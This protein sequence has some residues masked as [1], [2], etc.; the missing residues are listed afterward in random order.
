MA[1]IARVVAAEVPHHV[2]QRGNRRQPVFFSTADYKAYLRLMAA[3]CG[4]QGVEVWAY[5]LMTNHVHLIVVPGSEQ[6]LARAIGEAHRRYTV[7]VNQREHWRGYLWQG[8]FSSYP[9]DDQYLLAAVRYVELNPVRVGLA[10]RPWQYPWSSAAAHMR[11]RDDVLVRVKP[12]RDRVADWREYLSTEP[13]STDMDSLRRHM[14]SGRPL[15]SSEFVESLE[16]KLARSLVPRKRGPKPGTAIRP[17][18]IK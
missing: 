16:T 1:R 4:Q 2:V 7:R 18:P 10:E 15:G 6:G 9:L 14:R 8:R 3:W 13:D 5:C 11:N 17:Q 12:M